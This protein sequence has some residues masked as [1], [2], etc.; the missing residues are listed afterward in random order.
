MVEMTQA[1]IEEIHR[2][3]LYPVVRVRT[4]KAGGSGLIVYSKPTPE[5]PNIFE[6]Y[7]VTCHHVV[8]DA[9][10]FVSKWSS[11][12]QRNVTV[13]DRQPVF[14]EIFKYEKLSR[15]VGSISLNADIIAWDKNLDIALLKIRC[16]DEFKHIANLY[17]K[18][19]EDDI[20]LGRPL[21]T[22]GCSL[23]HEPIFTLGNIVAKH[24]II[25][26][27]EY[28]MSTANSIFGNSGGAVFL[29]DTYEYIGITARITTLQLGFGIDVVTWMGFF[30]PIPSIYSFFNDNFL[31]FIYD[32]TFTSKR[33]EE[34]RKAKMLEE[35]KK[36]VI[37]DSI[38]G[39]GAPKLIKGRD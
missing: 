18:G 21:V 38:S 39:S 8:E 33:C 22:C 24:D 20:K 9:I 36:L 25:E 35:E 34:L 4:E 31:M 27:K 1:K 7:V 37:P 23:G 12:A 28:W 2:K 15:C 5:D 14:V 16:E 26:N 11:I 19:K 17:P 32:A 3:V 10:Q 13:E 6:T 30:V 29:A